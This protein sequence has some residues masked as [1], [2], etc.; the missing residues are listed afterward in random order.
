MLLL[1]SFLSF[2]TMIYR[3]AMRNYHT[4]WIGAIDLYFWAG[5]G[6]LVEIE[7]KRSM[8]KIWHLNFSS[9][10]EMGFTIWTSFL[11]GSYFFFKMNFIARYCS[12][13]SKSHFFAPELLDF[14]VD[15]ETFACGRWKKKWSY[16]IHVVIQMGM[17]TCHIFFSWC[18]CN[19]LIFFLWLVSFDCTLLVSSVD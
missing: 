14:G 12:R 9:S 18:F 7:L 10:Q 4:N 19:C 2:N 13:K 15:K 6:V 5:R 16:L 1:V 8:W 17:Q 11:W 3:M